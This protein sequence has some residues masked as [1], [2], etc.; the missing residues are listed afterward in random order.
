M[1]DQLTAYTA[2]II[3]NA[4]EGT[5]DAIDPRHFQETI[6]YVEFALKI[7]DK[8][9]VPTGVTVDGVDVAPEIMYGNM[10]DAKAEMQKS[11]CD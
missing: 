5:R 4:L 10:D 6:Q 7:L 3:R 11:G 1:K 9:Y 2:C 8:V